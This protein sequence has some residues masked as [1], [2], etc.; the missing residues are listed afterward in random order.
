MILIIDD[1][2]S[3]F[4]SPLAISHTLQPRETMY[5]TW[6]DPSGKKSIKWAFPAVPKVSNCKPIDINKVYIHCKNLYTIMCG[7]REWGI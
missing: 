5:Y 7:V 6:D 4:R 2:S 3:L 1:S